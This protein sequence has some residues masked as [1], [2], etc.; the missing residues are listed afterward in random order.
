MLKY[1]FGS[2]PSFLLRISVMNS[3]NSEPK[4]TRMFLKILRKE[5]GNRYHQVID[6]D[7][8]KLYVDAVI[9]KAIGD[10]NNFQRHHRHFP[11]NWRHLGD[12]HL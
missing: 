1:D 7:N 11:I 4:L 5:L 6:S 3:R 2:A 8:F 10:I 12:C 9:H